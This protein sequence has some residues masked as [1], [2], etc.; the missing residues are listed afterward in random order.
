MLGQAWRAH[1]KAAFVL[2]LR[3][4]AIKSK[5]GRRNANREGAEGWSRLEAFLFS[6]GHSV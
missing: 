1:A 6:L 2:S 3:V 4:K 5:K